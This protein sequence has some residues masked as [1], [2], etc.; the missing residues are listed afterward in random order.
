MRNGFGEGAELA[1]A[2]FDAL[3]RYDLV[4]D[5]G[6]VNEDAINAAWSSRVGGKQNRR[7]AL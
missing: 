5:I 4:R 6:D 3:A 1:F 7:R 2:L